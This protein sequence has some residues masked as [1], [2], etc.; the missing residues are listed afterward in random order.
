[1]KCMDFDILSL[2]LKGSAEYKIEEKVISLKTNDL[3]FIPRH[4][5][6][7]LRAEDEHLI[8]FHFKTTCSHPL[9]PEYYTPKNPATFKVAFESAVKT[10]AA[11]K[12]GYYQKTTALFYNIL[13]EMNLQFD[14]A[15]N[16]AS[17]LRIKDALDYLHLNYRDSSL[18]VNQLCRICN[19]SD[20]QFRKCFHNVYGTTPLNYINQLRTDYAADLLANTDYSVK[21]ISEESGFTDDKYFSYVFKKYHNKTPS[22]QRQLK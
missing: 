4:S 17:Y 14:P 3:I 9:F 12:P 1:M 6:Y 5:H 21:H 16:N 20:T 7:S 13:A 18:C 19:L 11:H 10:W 22:A 2:R 15:Y 8:V